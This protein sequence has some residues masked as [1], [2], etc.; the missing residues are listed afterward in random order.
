MP[1]AQSGIHT[2]LNFPFARAGITAECTPNI[3]ML[4]MAD[5]D[6]EL[7]RRHREAMVGNGFRPRR[8]G[9]GPG[10]PGGAAAISSGA[11]DLRSPGV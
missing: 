6:V 8:Q 1:Y 9:V 2:P 4:A 5:M 11:S 10:A 3:E 7:L